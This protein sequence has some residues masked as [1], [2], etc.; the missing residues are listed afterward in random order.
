MREDRETL[1]QVAREMR[2]AM[3]PAEQL[4]WSHLRRRLLGYKFRRQVPIGQVIVDFACLSHRVVVEVDGQHHLGSVQDQ[5][6]DRW[7]AA[8]GF[9]VLRFQ[10]QEV[11]TDVASVL[12]RVSKQLP[13]VR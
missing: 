1:R 11:L 4:L 5:E 6:R 12:D 8:R 9:R 2:R 13:P 10:N 7:L 3:T